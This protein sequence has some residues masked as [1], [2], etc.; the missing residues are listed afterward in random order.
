MATNESSAV[1]VIDAAIRHVTNPAAVTLHTAAGLREAR[2]AVAELMEREQSLAKALRYV[3]A[4]VGDSGMLEHAARA[5]AESAL[6]RVV[7]RDE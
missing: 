6:A 5:A 7:W 3:M 2:A 1:D 4:C